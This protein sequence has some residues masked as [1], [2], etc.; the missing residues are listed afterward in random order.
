MACLGGVEAVIDKDRC[1]ALLARAVG[2]ERLIIATDIAGIEVDHGTPDARLLTS[3]RPPNSDNGS[4]PANTR[5][6]R[7]DQRSKRSATSC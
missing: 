1:A 6:V 5:P 2:P 7:W 3:I 4:R